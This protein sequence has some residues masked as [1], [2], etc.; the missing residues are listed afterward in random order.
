MKRILLIQLK[1]IGD[2]ILT[3]PALQ[4][5]RQQQPQAELVLIVPSMSADLAAALPVDRVLSYSSLRL[6]SAVWSSAMVGEW[7]ACYDFTGT[8]RSAAL[9]AL[10]GAEQRWGYSKFSGTGLRR[11]AYTHLCDASV[12]DL[13]TVDFHRALLGLPTGLPIRYGSLSIPAAPSRP[14]YA[15]VHPGTARAEKFWPSQRWAEVIHELVEQHALE[16]ILTGTGTGLEAEP[17]AELRQHLHAPVMDLTGQLSL[18]GTASVI[19]GAK[20]ALGVDSMAMHLA[21]LANVPQIVLYGPTN[22]YHWRPLQPAAQVLVP[23]L[24]EPQTDF[25]PKASGGSMLD[26]STDAVMQAVRAQLS[27][28]QKLSPL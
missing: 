14:A 16:V 18:L 6:N 17:L 23:G 15:V 12:R 26:I 10:S 24:L 19:A 21:A 1:R 3:A 27:G 11:R 25:Q 28:P 7:S 22:P 8:D 9:V 4:E 2:L 20:L 13:H 5:L